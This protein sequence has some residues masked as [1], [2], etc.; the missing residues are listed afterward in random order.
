LDD[1]YFALLGETRQTLGQPVDYTLLPSG[2][3]A[4]I[5]RRRSKED[6]TITHLLG[7]GDH[8]G[9]VQ[10]GFRWNAAVVQAA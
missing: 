5:D 4:R 3:L 9:G 6:P 10:Q 7:F 2:E 1:L 8:P